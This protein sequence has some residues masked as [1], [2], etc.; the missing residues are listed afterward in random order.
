M[1]CGGK[2]GLEDLLN[3]AVGA[4]RKERPPQVACCKAREKTGELELESGKENK[5]LHYFADWHDQ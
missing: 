4:E 3:S 2:A 5:K 1:W